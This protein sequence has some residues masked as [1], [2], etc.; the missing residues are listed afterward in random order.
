[1]A[2][3]AEAPRRAARN[4]AIEAIE[5]SRPSLF[6]RRHCSLTG[7][8]RRF[9]LPLVVKLRDWGPAA[10]YFLVGVA[11]RFMGGTFGIYPRTL[12][13]EIGAVSEILR[14]SQW[15]MTY[16]RGLAHERLEAEFAEAIGTRQA[17]A[18]ASG[19]VALQMSLRALGLKPGDE[20]IHQ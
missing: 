3:P 8:M 11:R 7:S 5:T 4:V 19:G 9:L 15:N 10:Y 18:V 1:A 2:G 17:I 20:A 13:D 16:G 6:V 12:G 14:S